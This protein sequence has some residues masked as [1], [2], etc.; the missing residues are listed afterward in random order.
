LQR[1]AAGSR[2]PLA[3]FCGFFHDL[4]K[5]ATDPACYPRHQGH[6]Q[7][8]FGM[9][10]E[11]CRRLRLPAHYGKALAWVSRLHGTFNLW[12]QLRDSTRI[13]MADQALKGGIADILPLVSAA[14]KAGGCEPAEWREALR[15]AGMSSIELGIDPQVLERLQPPR[16]TDH[17]LQRRVERFRS[18]RTASA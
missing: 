2:D 12:G 8:G 5:L 14:D 9:S 3:R 6:D 15:I 10:A 1:V 11:F 18:T 4:G 7:T 13:R 17:I 16:R